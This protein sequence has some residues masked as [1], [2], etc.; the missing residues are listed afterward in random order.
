M[1]PSL[2]IPTSAFGIDTR[3][4]LKQL[5]TATLK[6]LIS[7]IEFWTG[8]SPVFEEVPQVLEAKLTI[9]MLYCSL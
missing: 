2:T 7:Q 6:Y 4:D 5:S 1:K 3:N 9:S 8:D